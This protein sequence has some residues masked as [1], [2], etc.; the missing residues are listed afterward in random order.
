MSFVDQHTL[1]RRGFCICCVV[2]AG[3]AAKNGWLS[4]P[5]AYAEARN[6]VD[7]IRDEASKAPTKV[8]KLRRNASVLEGSGGHIRVLTGPD[9]TV[10]IDGGS[11]RRDTDP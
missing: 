7:L 1:S 10:F 4:P 2:A 5:Q 8:H 11:P 6:I 9:G 3:F